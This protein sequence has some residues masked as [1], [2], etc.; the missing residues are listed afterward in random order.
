PAAIGSVVTIN[1][2]GCGQTV[3]GGEEGRII[4]KNIPKLLLPVH[5]L[6]GG[7]EAEVV[8]AGDVPSMISGMVQIKAK[9]PAGIT[10][11]SVLVVITVGGVS[12]QTE[13]TVAIAGPSN[14]D[15]VGASLEE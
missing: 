3:P 1:A 12:S 15:A 7:F 8:D 2:T 13:V 6:I 4:D 9:V 11:G 5:V 14:L 10:G